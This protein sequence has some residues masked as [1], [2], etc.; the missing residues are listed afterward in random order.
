MLALVDK[1]LLEGRPEGLARALVLVCL[2]K[3]E[4]L[5]FVLVL[6]LAGML[7]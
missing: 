3:Q 6:L 5:F 4:F 1:R 7:R 2:P